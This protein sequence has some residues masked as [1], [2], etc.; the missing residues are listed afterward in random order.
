MF[1][2]GISK[3]VCNRFVK[4]CRIEGDRG[5]GVWSDGGVGGAFHLFRELGTCWRG[6]GGGETCVTRYRVGWAC[7]ST[8][9][10]LVA[11]QAGT[12]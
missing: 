4:L 1:R 3:I 5:G 7:D 10:W 8:Q 11:R 9:E 6:G 2:G 12:L